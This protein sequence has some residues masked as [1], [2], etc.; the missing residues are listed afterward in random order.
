M[1][2]PV[3]LILFFSPRVI[4]GQKQH[5]LIMNASVCEEILL[6]RNRVVDGCSVLVQDPCKNPSFSLV[7]RFGVSVS[8]PGS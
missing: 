2:E 3:P 4:W 1:S 6:L 8:L 7:Q 5:W